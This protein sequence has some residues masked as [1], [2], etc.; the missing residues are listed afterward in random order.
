MYKDPK[1]YEII[2]KIKGADLEG[3]EYEPLFKFFEDRRKD[4]CFRVIAA[5]FVD[6]DIGTGIVHCAPGFSHNHYKLCVENKIIKPD[7]PVL[8]IDANGKFTK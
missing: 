2:E 6:A 7:N 5:N 1:D 8:P 4:G 3:T